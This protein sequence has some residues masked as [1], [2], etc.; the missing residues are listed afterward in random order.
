MVKR[1]E[2]LEKLKKIN[3][4]WQIEDSLYDLPELN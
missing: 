3:G 1:T 4:K 2:Y